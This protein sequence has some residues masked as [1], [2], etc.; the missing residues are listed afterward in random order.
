MLVDT[1]AG[2][3][4][5]REVFGGISGNVKQKSHYGSNNHRF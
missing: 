2:G 1:S 4:K 5:F 3:Y